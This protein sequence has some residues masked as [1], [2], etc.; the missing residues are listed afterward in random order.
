MVDRRPDFLDD[1]VFY[2][3]LFL[4]AANQVK[5]SALYK[6]VR[7]LC[8][9]LAQPVMTYLQS[10]KGGTNAVLITP[11]SLTEAR[12]Q[13][14]PATLVKNPETGHYNMA[15]MTLEYHFHEQEDILAAA[16]YSS[17][18]SSWA[19]E[20][21]LA[22]EEQDTALVQP[23]LVEPTKT[24]SLAHAEATALGRLLT[25]AEKADE[26][27]LSRTLDHLYT[28]M[29]NFKRSLEGDEGATYR[30][31]K[32]IKVKVASKHVQTDPM[33]RL[34]YFSYPDPPQKRRTAKDRLGY[35]LIAPAPARRPS[36]PSTPAPPFRGF[37]PYQL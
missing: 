18:I 2:D 37:R 6:Q 32:R 15:K 11:V 28:M 10:N 23:P 8:C 5:N 4:A 19:M 33:P 16:V 12:P 36:P 30:E 20:M 17:K 31:S 34:E 21:D 29:Q 24:N 1:A 35:T 27:P 22:D 26:R 13:S 14:S 25:I 3:D 7:Q 9:N